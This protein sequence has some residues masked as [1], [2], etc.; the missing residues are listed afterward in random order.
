[1]NRKTKYITGFVLSVLVICA[2]MIPAFALTESD[3][4]SQVSAS[5]KEGVA[6]NLFVW[7]LCAVAFLK[8]SQKIDSFMQ[9]LG[10]NVGHT[11]GSMLAEVMLA[12]RSIAAARGVA[13]RGR[14][15]NAGR[16]G[17]TDG[18]GGDSN[19]FLQGGLA[20]VVN[21]SF[22]ME[23]LTLSF[24]K[25]KIPA[26]GS[27]QFELPT[28]DPE[29]PEYVRFL[30]GIILF[31]HASGAYWPEGMEYDDNTVPLCST[32]D[33]KQGY[34][35]PGGACAACE[36]NRYGTATDGKGKACKN[37]RILYLLQDGDYIPVQLSLPP[38]S[39]RPFNDFMNAAFVARRRPAWSS[40]VQIG[41]KRV[42]NGNTYSVATFRKMADL[43]SEKVGEFRAFVE[44]FR[45]QAKEMLKSRAELSAARENEDDQYTAAN[46]EYT[47]ADSGDH[48]CIS[49]A[50]VIDG[51][52]EELPQ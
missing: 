2:L 13:G 4:Q 44:S 25:V 48:F 33:G 45:Q 50:A 12:A 21:R 20:G 10:I 5:G 14:G 46:T 51:E 27:L 9:G 36:L 37:M 24:P 34:G 47:V 43:P 17:S 31:H 29:N 7:F 11:G 52:R 26:G 1:M 41:L 40:V 39:L 35:T 28:G 49:G 18:S 15:G 3:V 6:E 30:Q 23:G 16:S 19:T 22:Y 38:T 32:V 8:I 42:D